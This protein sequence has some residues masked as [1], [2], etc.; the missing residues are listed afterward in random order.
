[1]AADRI[2]TQATLAGTKLET[3]LGVPGRDRLGTC[4]LK[5]R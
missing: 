1:M 3:K 4:E 2:M 5:W